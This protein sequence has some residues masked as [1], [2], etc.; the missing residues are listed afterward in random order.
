MPREGARYRGY[1]RSPHSAAPVPRRAAPRTEDPS[2]GPAPGTGRTGARPPPSLP[3]GS[4]PRAAAGPRAERGP[5]ATPRP[6]PASA[7]RCAPAP[8]TQE[9]APS[10]APATQGRSDPG[11]SRERPKPRP[12]PRPAQRPARPG[13]PAARP[14]QPLTAPR[15]PAP[16]APLPHPVRGHLAPR[17]ANAA[18]NP[19]RRPHATRR[20]RRGPDPRYLRPPQVPGLGCGR[21]VRDEALG[22]LNNPLLPLFP[23]P[24]PVSVPKWRRPGPQYSGTSLAR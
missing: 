19:A 13:P 24:Q 14:T 15:R 22:T 16:D 6:Q 18:P 2:A 7:G 17:V 8:G 9:T 4:P 20:R 3:L 10:G 11:G 12:R 23:P 1:V 21:W 5:G